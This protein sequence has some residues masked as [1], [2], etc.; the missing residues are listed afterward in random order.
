L[1]IIF[2]EKKME[3][4]KKRLFGIIPAAALAF[5][6]VFVGCGGGKDVPLI[7]KT[8]SQVN[9]R[10]EPSA[11]S[12]VL[13]TLGTGFRVFVT[14]PDKDGWRPVKRNGVDGYI[15]SGYLTYPAKDTLP[16]GNTLLSSILWIVITLVIAGA[17][18]LL[19][20]IPFIGIL[21]KIVAVLAII[22][23][24]VVFFV[25]IGPRANWWEL[26]LVFIL[27]ALVGGGGGGWIIFIW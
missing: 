3:M 5:G 22:V 1:A 21:F 15:S 4:A 7:S 24:W 20:L 19:G 17:G 2:K 6:L 9:M 8:T 27:P 18:R 14:G 16:F 26:L 13:M 12:E 23:I 10:A 11:E 25:E